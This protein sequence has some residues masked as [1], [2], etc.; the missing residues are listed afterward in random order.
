M[1][2]NYWLDTYKIMEEVLKLLHKHVSFIEVEK[3]APAPYF[4]RIEPNGAFAL[5]CEDRKFPMLPTSLCTPMGNLNFVRRKSG[6]DSDTSADAINA[7]LDEATKVLGL[8]EVESETI[9]GITYCRY[10]VTRLPWRRG[11]Y[12]A[13]LSCM[14]VFKE[15]SD[16]DSSR[17]EYAKANRMFN[18]VMSLRGTV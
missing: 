5:T 2:K 18:R 4:D 6:F 16:E 17:R 11:G 14:P 13:T 1:R 10:A 8:I 7:F 12:R 15:K 9:Y 3:R